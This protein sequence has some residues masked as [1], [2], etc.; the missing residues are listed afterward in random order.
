M[1][2]AV[3]FDMDGVLVDSEPL[4]REAWSIV[5]QRYGIRIL[6]EEQATLIGK[7]A[8]AVLEFYRNKKPLPD[9]VLSEKHEIF[10]RIANKRLQPM[11]H[12]KKILAQLKKQG[13]P[14][15]VASSSSTKRINYSLSHTSMISYFQ[16]LRR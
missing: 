11:P 6:Q 16:V 13:V 15:A 3:I 9:T 4:D 2:N 7:P 1:S 5:L 8:A 10:Y 12:V 14:L